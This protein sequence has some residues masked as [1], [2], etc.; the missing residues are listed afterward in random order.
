[1]KSYCGLIISH[2]WPIESEIIFYHFLSACRNVWKS[3]GASRNPRSFQGEGLTSI[4]AK[5]LGGNGT[6]CRKFRGASDISRSLE[7]LFLASI[8]AKIWGGNGSNCPCISVSDGP[9]L[10]VSKFQKR[11][12]LFSFEPKNE[13]NYFLT[14]ALVSKMSQIKKMKALYY[15]N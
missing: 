9:E 12:F 7:G 4:P 15:I 5:I 10:K 3:G 14:S 2:L 6:D 8:P 1:M 11:I 13:R